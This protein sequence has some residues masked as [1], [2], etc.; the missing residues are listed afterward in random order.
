MNPVAPKLELLL[1]EV[2][3]WGPG[4]AICAIGTA[5]KNAGSKEAFR[6]VDHALPLSFA[7][8]V[9]TYRSRKEFMKNGV[10][11]YFETVLGGCSPHAPGSNG[12]Q[13]LQADFSLLI[14]SQDRLL[15][16]A[17]EVDMI[18]GQANSAAIERP[19]RHNRTLP[20]A[21]GLMPSAGFPALRV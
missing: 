1:S 12:D 7:R 17:D 19:V 10:N 13:F 15:P 18:C 2:A 3:S 21:E 11:A 8:L 4:A 5:I 16:V 9:S 20:I 6:G 14:P